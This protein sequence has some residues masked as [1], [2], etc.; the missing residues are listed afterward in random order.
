MSIAS[1]ITRLQNAKVDIKIAIEAKGVEIPSNATLD[2]YSDYVEEISTGITPTGTINITENGTSDVT[3]YASASVNV[4]PDLETKSITI[5]ENTTTT[6]TPTQGK[7]GLSS[8]QVTTNVSGGGGSGDTLE[9]TNQVL[10]NYVSKLTNI[11]N[12]YSTTTQNNVTLYT[13]VVDYST[14]L[15]IKASTSTSSYKI[16]WLRTNDIYVLTGTGTNAV[17][18]GCEFKINFQTPYNYKNWSNNLSIYTRSAYKQYYVSQGYSSVEAC[19]E[20]IQSNSTTYTLKT[21]TISGRY[22]T[23]P[24]ITNTVVLNENNNW[25]PISAQK[26][27]SNETIEVIS[28]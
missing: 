13:P 28:S 23:I 27:S 17:I 18:G 4:Q 21:D 8:V 14:Y 11:P 3:N 24:L 7:D 9:E 1:E 12:T 26:I 25:E 15:I 19:I 10:N 6:I 16:M 2:K 20:A 22:F 5:T